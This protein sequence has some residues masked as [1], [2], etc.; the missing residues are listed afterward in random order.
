[1]ASTRE[2]RSIRASIAADERWSRTTDRAA[3]TAAARQ[4]FNDRFEQL[5]DPAG[6]LAPDERTRRA[7]SARRAYMKRLALRSAQSRR[8]AAGLRHAAAD[9]KR[10]ATE[11]DGAACDL[12]RLADETDAELRAVQDS[13]VRCPDAARR[14]RPGRSVP[15][16]AETLS[17]EDR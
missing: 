10:T 7:A 15:G 17:E 12:D 8:R 3:A 11:L 2:E 4:A 6:E 1:M 14:P 13:P 16:P 5:V 9:S